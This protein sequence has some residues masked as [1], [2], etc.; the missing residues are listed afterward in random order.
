MSRMLSISS[1]LVTGETPV[2]SFA[3]PAAA[4]G[5]EVEA[6]VTLAGVDLVEAA[7]TLAGVDLVEAA[8]TWRGGFG[9]GG[10]H[11][12]GGGFGGGGVHFGGSGFGGGGVHFGGGGLGGSH[13]SAGGLA[14]GG[15]MGGNGSGI[16]HYGGV[17]AAH[18]G[19]ISR[20]AAIR[21][22][23]ALPAG[24]AW[25]AGTTSGLP[26]RLAARPGAANR[27]SP[28]RGFQIELEPQFR[29]VG[30]LPNFVAAEEN[31][32][33]AIRL[34]GSS[35]MTTLVGTRTSTSPI[36]LLLPVFR[37]RGLR[38]ATRSCADNTR[39]IDAY[40]ALP[41]RHAAV[42]RVHR[43]HRRRAAIGHSGVR[44]FIRRLTHTTANARRVPPKRLPRGDASDGTCGG[45]HAAGREG[46]STANTDFVRVGCL[47][48]GRH[49]MHAARAL[50][51]ALNWDALYKYYGDVSTYTTQFAH[52]KSTSPI[53][54][55]RPTPASCWPTNMKCW[56]TQR[57]RFT[58][59]RRSSSC[60][61][62]NSRRRL[63]M[64]LGG[65]AAASVAKTAAPSAGRG[66]A[67]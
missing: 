4:H 55:T 65:K 31:N 8:V 3:Q 66:Q 67:R 1:L 40:V 21:V 49:R 46:P 47:S 14:R 37:L 60:P 56:A 38:L 26:N 11:F 64:D 20:H 35:H 34:W 6:A 15:Q 19:G 32:M 10:G 44:Q 62:T 52:W 16:A 51:P 33:R 23:S 28:R 43:R 41:P 48:S 53:I 25:Q 39:T 30:T 5:G 27:A 59:T 7:V 13:I 9:G 18:F 42:L 36:A 50:G 24:C 54:R 58:I 2:F 63:V 17:G 57:N 12:G 22:G 61:P 45:G 29:S